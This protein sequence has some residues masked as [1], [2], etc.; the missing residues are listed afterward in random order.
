[1]PDLPDND[2]QRLRWRRR[3]RILTVLAILAA[4]AAVVFRKPWFEGNFGVVAPGRVY[5]SAQ[6]GEEL[7]GRIHQHKIASILNLRG[8]SPADPF[9]AD[10]VRVTKQLGV[11]FYDFPMLATRRPSRRELLVL[12]DLLGRC[13]YP[14][15]IHCKSGSDRTAL[16]SALYLINEKPVGVDR[17][18]KEFSIGYGHVGLLGTE[19]LQRP[20]VEYGRWLASQHL[21]HT[22]E[23]FRRWVER[24]YENDPFLPATRPFLPLEPGPRPILAGGGGDARVAIRAGRWHVERARGQRIGAP[25]PSL[26]NVSTTSEATSHSI[27]TSSL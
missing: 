19:Q 5:R 2:R 1:M 21:G 3:R 17:A 14:L 8:G 26:S 25:G 9:Y 24:D 15:L 18:L 12:L 7:A 6:P 23:R 10:E 20:F 16:A 13:R 22:P 4:M 11:D 27:E